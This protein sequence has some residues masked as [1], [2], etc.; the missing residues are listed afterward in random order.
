MYNYYLNSYKTKIIH[1]QLGLKIKEFKILKIN[2]VNVHQIFFNII[3]LQISQ[4]HRQ[5]NCLHPVHQ[6][7]FCHV[8]TMCYNVRWYFRSTY[9]QTSRE[10]I[11]EFLMQSKN[12][13]FDISDREILQQLSSYVSFRELWHKLQLIWTQLLSH[14]CSLNNVSRCHQSAFI[15]MK[16][17]WNRLKI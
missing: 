1:G 8:F 7:P 9:G 2:S 4:D 5:S 15:I 16:C 12:F 13:W 3:I 17:F 6:L 11:L 10:N 14:T